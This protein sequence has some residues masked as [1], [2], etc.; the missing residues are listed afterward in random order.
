MAQKSRDKYPDCTHLKRKEIYKISVIAL[1]IILAVVIIPVN[2]LVGITGRWLERERH[3][4]AVSA[5]GL[6]DGSENT[7]DI[8]GAGKVGMSGWIMFWPVGD[9]N[10]TLWAKGSGTIALESNGKK[11]ATKWKPIENYGYTQDWIF[12]KIRLD[13]P[14]GE[15]PMEINVE[16]AEGTRPTLGSI[17]LSTGPYTYTPTSGAP[18]STGPYNTYVNLEL[19]PTGVIYRGTGIVVIN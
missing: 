4:F 7:I 1:V 17:T 16:L 9:F 11:F 12:M 18:T 15:L 6:S 5:T 3:S 13:E 8:R 19:T 14:V 2:D 10:L